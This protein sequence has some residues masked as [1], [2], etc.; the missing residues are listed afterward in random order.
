MNLKTALLDVH[1]MGEADSLTVAAGT[2]VVELME[3][4]G[5][6]VAGE[7]QRRWPARPTIVLCGPGNKN[8]ES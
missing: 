4:A 8:Y 1:R 6:A 3:N 7:I 5:S 2:S